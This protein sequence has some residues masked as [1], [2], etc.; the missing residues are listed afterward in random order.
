MKIRNQGKGVLTKGVSVESSVTANETKKVP[1]DNGPSSTFGTQSATAKR[2]HILAN[3]FLKTPFSRFLRRSTEKVTFRAY[4]KVTKKSP[5]HNFPVFF[6]T[7]VFCYF[8]RCFEFFG[9]SGSVWPF[10]PHSPRPRIVETRGRTPKLRM[11]R[12]STFLG[13]QLWWSRIRAILCRTAVR[14]ELRCDCEWHHNVAE[15]HKWSE[16]QDL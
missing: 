1:K 5:K 11:H 2:G 13:K 12:R 8:F 15:R 6:V 14:W 4:P 7:F 10:A 16:S 9:L 3:P